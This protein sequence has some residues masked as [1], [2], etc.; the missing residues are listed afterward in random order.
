M[1]DTI[2]MESVSYSVRDKTILNNITLGEVSPTQGITGILGPSDLGKS[3]LLKLING[4]ISPESGKL[5]IS[6]K[7]IKEWN[8]R[9]LRREVGMVL[10]KPYFFPGTVSDNLNQGPRYRGVKLTEDELSLLLDRVGLNASYLSRK[11]NTMSEGEKQRVSMARTLANDPSIL[12]L[13][14]P[15]SALDIASEEKI[16]E[17]LI[18]LSAEGKLIVLISH[19]PMQLKKLAG[20]IILVNSGS[21][22]VDLQIEELFATY[23]MDNLKDYFNDGID[24]KGRK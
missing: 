6:G 14:E 4:L 12:L 3:T 13:D 23:S 24:P 8:P 20:R 7:D 10:Q 11:S 9:H 22:E 16:E 15:T 17:L 19:D 2:A 21:V 1:L 18:Q 5:T